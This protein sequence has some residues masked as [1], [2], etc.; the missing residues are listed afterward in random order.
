M[1]HDELRQKKK[2]ISPEFSGW[3]Q[4]EIVLLIVTRQKVGLGRNEELVRSEGGERE[5][6]R[7]ERKGV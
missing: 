1:K 7:K 4:F 3:L 6:V 2:A 5:E